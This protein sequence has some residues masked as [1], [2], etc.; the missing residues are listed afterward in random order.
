MIWINCNLKI[1]TYIIPSGC[2]TEP[3]V[4]ESLDLKG[5]REGNLICYFS[6]ALYSVAQVQC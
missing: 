3:S 6:P 4:G 2:I 5:E 1:N